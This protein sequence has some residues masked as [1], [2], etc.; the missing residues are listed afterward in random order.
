MVNKFGEGRVFVVGDAAH[1]HSPTGG[2]GMNTGVQDSV[3]IYSF[4]VYR[5][6]TIC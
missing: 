2:Q 6:R 1:V 3:R 5:I 4:S